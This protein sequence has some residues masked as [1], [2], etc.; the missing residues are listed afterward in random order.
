MRRTFQLVGLAIVGLIAIWL[1][2]QLVGIVF[3][4]VFSVV[5]ILIRLAAAVALVVLAYVGYQRLRG[6]SGPPE[7]RI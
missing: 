2:F 5:W 3:G 6:G 4:I 7:A 1:A